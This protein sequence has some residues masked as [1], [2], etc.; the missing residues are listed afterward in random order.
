MSY[1]VRVVGVVRSVQETAVAMGK[2]VNLRNEL[3]NLN[4]SDS[5]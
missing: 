5:V 4:L 1:V 3:G 2:T